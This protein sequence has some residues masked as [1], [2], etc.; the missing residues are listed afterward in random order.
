MDVTL[1]DWSRACSSVTILSTTTSIIHRANSITNT[2]KLDPWW[3]NW[4]LLGNGP[5]GGHAATPKVIKLDTADCILKTPTWVYVIVVIFYS[6]LC[7]R[8]RAPRVKWVMSVTR[9]CSGA[10]QRGRWRARTS[11]QLVPNTSC[12]NVSY[13]T[14]VALDSRWETSATLFRS[15]PSVR[16]PMTFNE[17]LFVFLTVQQ[18]F[19]YFVRDLINFYN[20]NYFNSLMWGFQGTSF[21][22]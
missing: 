17:S 18:C 4:K 15:M 5:G 9:G 6:L 11:V 13:E 10:R 14:S 8:A 16:W 22:I 1:L 12:C 19:K 3:W 21:S 2:A 20:L 7:I